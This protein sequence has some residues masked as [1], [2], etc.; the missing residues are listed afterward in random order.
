MADFFKRNVFRRRISK[1]EDQEQVGEKSVQCHFCNG[2][3][4]IATGYNK[5]EILSVV[6]GY[7][8]TR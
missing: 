3:T 2:Y 7:L 8:H 6:G 1:E 5:E 4:N